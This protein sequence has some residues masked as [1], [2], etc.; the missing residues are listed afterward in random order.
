MAFKWLL[1]TGVLLATASITFSQARALRSPVFTKDGEL[2]L[3]SGFRNGSS[4]E[5]PSLRTGST[6]VR[7]HFQSFTMFTSSRQIYGFIKRTAA[8]RKGP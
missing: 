8:S 3:P 1:L 4:L 2:V 6:T 7:P 5:V